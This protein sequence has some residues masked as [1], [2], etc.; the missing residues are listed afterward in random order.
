MG[1]NHKPKDKRIY[2]NGKSNKL[3]S[4]ENIELSALKKISCDKR[5]FISREYK[6]HIASL[7]KKECDGKLTKNIKIFIDFMVTYENYCNKNNIYTIKYDEWFSKEEYRIGVCNDLGVAYSDKGLNVVPAFG[8]GSSFDKMSFNNNAQ[9]MKVTERY[10]LY[11]ND[12]RYE[13]LLEYYKEK[14]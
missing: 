9:N 14:K 3:F 4:Y 6:N 7:Y 5:I 8:N 13:S 2:G 10:K 12:K 11:E 1:N